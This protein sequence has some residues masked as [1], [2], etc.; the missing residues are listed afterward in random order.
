M[1]P[2]GQEP[3][4]NRDEFE[5]EEYLTRLPFLGTNNKDWRWVVK[6]FRI[7]QSVAE[8]EA[9]LKPIPA[10]EAKETVA[11]LVRDAISKIPEFG[12]L[13]L[14]ELSRAATDR[15]L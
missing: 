1:M 2:W 12:L 6:E 15:N 11:P 14:E 3:T 10:T 4:A 7:P 13:Y 5:N 9:S 8:I